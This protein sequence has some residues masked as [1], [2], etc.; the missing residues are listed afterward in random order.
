MSGAE[1]GSAYVSLYPKLANGFGKDAEKSIGG[2][3]DGGGIGSK[4]GGSFTEGLS[5]ALSKF[6]A[7]A[8]IGAALVAIGKAGFDAYAKVEEGA[9]N[10]ILATGATGDA[11]KQLT[12]V[13]KDVARNV[14]GDFGDIGS[15]VGELNTRL[16]LQGGALE[17]ASEAAMRYAKVNGQDAKTAIA[18]VTRMMNSA[19]ISSDEYASTLDK[20][21]VAA[22]QSGIDVGQLSTTVTDNAAS[23][24]ELGFTTD[25]SIAMLANFEKA[26]ANSGAVLAGMKKGVANWAKEGMSAKEG[27]ESFVAGIQDGSVSSADAIELF[28]ARAGVTMYDAA[29]KGQLDFQGMFDAIENGSEGMTEQMYNDTL[30]AS[31]KMDL[32][33]QNITLAGAELFAPA[34]EAISSFL[35]DTVVPFAQSIGGYIDQVKG[36]AEESGIAE[37][38]RTGAEKVGNALNGVISFITA[39]VMPVIEKIAQ[40]VLPVAMQIG[41]GVQDVM[42]QVGGIVNEVMTSIGGL[43]QDVWPDIGDTVTDV[44]GIISNV[45]IPVWEGI[46]AGI[47][48]VLGAIKA[49]FQAVWPVISGIVKTAVSVIKTV[50]GGIS[51]VVS[52]VSDTFNRV[53]EAITQPIEAA[54][55]VIKGIIDAIKGFFSNFRITIPHIPTPHFGINP[56]G[57]QVG[58]LLQGKIPTLAVDWYATGGIFPA[59]SPRVIGIGDAREPEVAAPLSK[60]QGMLGID[61]ARDERPNVYVGDIMVSPQSELYGLLMKVG[62][63]MLEDNRRRS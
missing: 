56:P 48:A 21:T 11:A 7:P 35:S 29:Q 63:T 61:G 22:Q 26:G 10:V 53:K 44:M 9:N 3:I 62:E 8:A 30:T 52:G 38:V 41:Q 28:G 42:N 34:A 57:W 6:A 58:D 19:G 60:L 13:Y 17:E 15:A 14:V 40:T 36:M 2:A 31:E 59:N 12:G 55:N 1:L 39:S 54:K 49:V 50:I 4:I 24:K 5:G 33:M 43:I 16:G 47:T 25:E 45:V 37:F 51:T 46:K 27:F 18:D 20:L 23:F 32:A